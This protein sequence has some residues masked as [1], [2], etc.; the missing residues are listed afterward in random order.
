MA[1]LNSVKTLQLD[2][3][4][5]NQ[6]RCEFRL[7]ADK[8]YLSNWRLADIGANGTADANG[9]RY[10]HSSGAYSLIKS[11]VL[12]N[13]NVV[14]AN[15]YNANDYLAFANIGRTNSN[16]VNMSRFL[17]RNQAGYDFSSEKIALAS[18]YTAGVSAP[19]TVTN[20]DATTTRAWLDLSLPL[21][22]LKASPTVDAR[23][24]QN[25]RLVIEWAPHTG[26]DLKKI[27][28]SSDGTG[29]LTILRPSIILDEMI[30]KKAISR[31]QNRPIPYINLDSERVVVDAITGTTQNVNQR[32]RAF[33]DRRINR[34]LM[35]NKNSAV[36]NASLGE[37][38]SQAM[39][40]ENIQ[41]TL[42]GQQLMPYK[43][44]DTPMKKQTFLA[45]SWGFRNAPQGSQFFSSV[46]YPEYNSLNNL[47]RNLSYGG[48]SINAEIHELQL[49][50]SREAFAS[51]SGITSAI[52]SYS[53]ANPT[54]VTLDSPL[55]VGTI[56][57]TIEQ[58]TISDAT[59]TDA[60]TVNKV[61]ALV[62]TN[63]VQPLTYE[64]LGVDGS[65]LTITDKGNM[66][67]TSQDQINSSKEKFDLLFWG[68]VNKVMSVRDN[69]VTVA[70]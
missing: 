60:S 10:V 7:P 44:I 12:Y 24:L 13:D 36:V 8:V 52:S 28:A 9:R 45:D 25:L 57:S 11:I 14:I 66:T 40:K 53:G 42:N 47:E 68:E 2:P 20:D 50:Y 46:G 58:V 6:Q 15:L 55:Y 31:V 23:Q 37:N 49:Q 56:V 21:P 48:L 17:N 22:F 30:D 29:A 59:G 61:H 26:A 35:I 33:D 1:L 64:L 70:V 34:L 38:Y 69:R 62:A 19:E 39:F 41:F 43:G 5:F 16:S 3:V 54:V 65:S 18:P 32:L 51:A 63:S 67:V 27:L 4:T